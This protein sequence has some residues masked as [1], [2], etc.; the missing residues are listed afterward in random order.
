M[1]KDR[2]AIQY[3]LAMYEKDY[4]FFV[5]ESVGYESVVKHSHNFVEIVYVMSGKAKQLIDDCEVELSVGDMFVIAGSQQHSILPMGNPDEFVLI[6]IIFDKSFL[7]VDYSLLSKCEI[8]NF[9]ESSYLRTLFQDALNCYEVRFGAFDLKVKG[10]VYQILAAYF[11]KKIYKVKNRTKSEYTSAYINAVVDYIKK[12]YSEKIYLR[13]IAKHVGLT[14]MYLQKV[15]KKECNTTIYS[16]LLRYRIEQ[17]CVLLVKTD[18][19]VI[20]ICDKI[21]FFDFKNFY[22]YFKK[23]FNMTPIQYRKLYRKREND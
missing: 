22:Y 10:F 7:D 14:E 23:I 8:I 2:K 11:D 17:C 3:N 18:D 6:N 4:P 21:G 5:G 16:Y 15:F 1:M 13:D 9:Y 12:H 20:D 19:P